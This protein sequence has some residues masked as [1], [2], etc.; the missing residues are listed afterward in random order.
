MLERG[1]LMGG[2]FYPTLAH[3]ED[4]VQ[5]CLDAADEV[6]PELADAAASGDVTAR[7]PGPIKRSGFAR[8]T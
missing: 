8:L 7:L 2:A 3:T 1:F 4:H 5:R 6:V